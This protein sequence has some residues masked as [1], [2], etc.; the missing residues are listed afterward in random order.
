MF[1]SSIMKGQKVCA[2]D[3]LVQD[4]GGTEDLP[5]PSSVWPAIV[6]PKEL[7]PGL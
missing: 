3:E 6:L 1:K 7:T 4:G 2:Q 5:S